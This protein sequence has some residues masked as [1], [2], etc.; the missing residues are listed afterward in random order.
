MCSACDLSVRANTARRQALADL[1]CPITKLPMTDPVKAP[2]G[3]V[4]DRIA[5]QSYVNEHKSSPKTFEPM[6]NSF[7]PD[8]ARKEALIAFMQNMR[9]MLEEHQADDPVHG[10]DI[11]LSWLAGEKRRSVHFT[12]EELEAHVRSMKRSGTTRAALNCT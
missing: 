5:I 10:G 9:S 6:S 2:D 8:V 7:E 4:Y 12:R 1:L 11:S 3:Y